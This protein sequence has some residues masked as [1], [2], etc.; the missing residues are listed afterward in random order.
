MF[1]VNSQIFYVQSS[2]RAATGNKPLLLLLL[3]LVSVDC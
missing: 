2:I 3:L 1:D